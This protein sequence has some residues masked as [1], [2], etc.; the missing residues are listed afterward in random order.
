MPIFC[1]SPA[2]LSRVRNPKLKDSRAFANV[3]IPGLDYVDVR[4]LNEIIGRLDRLGFT[5]IRHGH[6]FADAVDAVKLLQALVDNRAQLIEE[7]QGAMKEELIMLIGCVDRITKNQV[8]V[9]NALNRA[10]KREQGNLHLG[11]K[12]VSI[13]TSQ[14]TAK[15]AIFADPRSAGPSVDLKLTLAELTNS[16][17]LLSAQ[18]NQLNTTIT[19][20]KISQQN[21]F[22]TCTTAISNIQ[23]STPT[24]T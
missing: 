7:A 16:N 22:S 12:R 4:H 2:S 19:S 24:P 6:L 15:I 13:A 10:F 18:I 17:I 14:L 9:V 20:L 21:H 8:N 11:L 1:K 3:N 5:A 23:P